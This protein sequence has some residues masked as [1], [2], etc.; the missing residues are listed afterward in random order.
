MEILFVLFSAMDILLGIVFLYLAI[1]YIHMCFITRHIVTIRLKDVWI[2]LMFLG[3][4]CLYAG[5]GYRELF[6]Q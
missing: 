2:S 6:A 4:A 1:G 5:V 3:A